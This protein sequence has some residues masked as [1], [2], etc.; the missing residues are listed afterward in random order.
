M[1]L[2]FE[3]ITRQQ[4]TKNKHVVQS[5]INSLCLGRLLSIHVVVI[6]LI[7]QTPCGSLFDILRR[8]LRMTLLSL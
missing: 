7:P 1:H 2:A 6:S 4:Q 3:P 8:L 5:S